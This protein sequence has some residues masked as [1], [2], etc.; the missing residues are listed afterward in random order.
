MYPLP[1]C[2]IP[3]RKT[4]FDPKVTAAPVPGCQQAYLWPLIRATPGREVRR[5]TGETTIGTR[6]QGLPSTQ[7]HPPCILQPAGPQSLSLRELG[8]GWGRGSSLDP[9]LLSLMHPQPGLHFSS[10]PAMLLQERAWLTPPV[11]VYLEG[12]AA[13][14]PN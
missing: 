5:A 13:I 8:T 2:P 12:S 6:G 14:F 4:D 10:S 9:P 11:P 7:E 3:D 1:R